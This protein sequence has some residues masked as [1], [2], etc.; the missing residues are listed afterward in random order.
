MCEM[1]TAAGVEVRGVA[2][3]ASERSGRIDSASY[4]RELG[5]QPEVHRGHTAKRIRPEFEF[6]DRGIHYH[7]LDVG[8]RDMHA[9]QKVVGKQFDNLFDRELHT[10]KPDLLLAFGG[11]PGDR[12]RYERASRQGTRIVFSL[13]NEGYLSQVGAEMLAKMDGV[14]TCSQYLT[15][16]Y[17]ISLEIE[18]TPLPLP[19]DIEDVVARERDPIFFTMIN[20]APEKGLMVMA[21]L[22]EDFSVQRPDIPLMIVE[23]RGSAGRLVAAGL[24]AGYDLR[25]HENIMMSAALAQPKEIYLATRVLLAPSLWQEPAGR[26]AAEAVLNGIPPI[27]SDRG[28]LP[29]TCNGA[30]FY[31]PIPPEITPAQPYPVPTEVVEPWMKLM[32][33]LADDEDFYRDESDRALEAGRIYRPENLAP[34]YVGYFSGILGSVAT[35]SGGAE[36]PSKISRFDL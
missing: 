8:P 7:L 9:W 6:L 27:V 10:F 31:V 17:K 5:I 12:R 11:L 35:G 33:R 21:R 22:A 13:R 18:S 15:D 26:V 25:R 14:L 34:R 19:M 28:G 36:C 16:L 32:T 1:L 3:T 4:L 24:N 29:E 2:T 30:G 23:S 20:P